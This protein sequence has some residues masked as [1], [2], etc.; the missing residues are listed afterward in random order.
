MKFIDKLLSA[1][2]KNKSLLCV[3]LDPDRKLMP[4]MGLL[5]FNKAIIDATIGLVCAYKPN[6]A[7]Y[8][9]MGMEGL[10]ALKET[11]A[12][13]PDDILIIGDAKR[14]DI[15]NT[16]KAYAEALFNYFGVDAATVNPY[17]GYDS[18]EPFL[19]YGEKGIFILCRTSNKGAV[20][21]QDIRSSGGEPL[22][23][24][25][26]RKALEWNKD[27][28][29][30]L[31]VGATYPQ[32]LKEIRGLCPDMPLLIP[33]IGAQGGDLFQA[34]KDGTDVHGEKAVISTSRQVLYASRG[35]DFAQAARRSAQ[36]LRDR[37]N[38]GLGRIRSGDAETGGPGA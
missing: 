11:I 1:S 23:R 4:D 16:A 14:G 22:Y 31:V 5:E 3:G 7:F 35:D 38:E 24:S 30:G 37:I 17:L 27:A 8:E 28:Q 6:F 36:D 33:G 15:G 12:Y 10:N 29:I 18:I 13:I 32:E 21:F 26:A 20:D 25:V 9:A 2:R 19:D 34:V